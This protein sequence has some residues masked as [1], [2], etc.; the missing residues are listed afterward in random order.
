[1]TITVTMTMRPLWLDPLDGL[2]KV[3]TRVEC[4]FV[5]T[6]DAGNFNDRIYDVVPM[7]T[8]NPA[9]FT[10]FDQ[11]TASDLLAWVKVAK[12]DGY[13]AWRADCETRAIAAL[14][15]PKAGTGAA[16]AA[17]EG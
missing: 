12:G 13:D 6:D 9:T 14:T 3:I 2:S 1:M 8:P 5:A 11:V 17:P 15:A 16:V 7:S 10:Q 4:R